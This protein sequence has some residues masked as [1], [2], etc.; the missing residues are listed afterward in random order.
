VASAGAGVL[1]R[2]NSHRERRQ[3]LAELIV[4]FARDAAPFVF[5]REHEAREGIRCAPAPPPPVS[6]P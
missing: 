2:P 1:E 3:L 5:L 6:V 4:H